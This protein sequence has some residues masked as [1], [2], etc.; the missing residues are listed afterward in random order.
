M[1]VGEGPG[2]REDIQGRPFVGRAG[3]LLDEMLAAIGLDRENVYVTNV[4][5]CRPVAFESGRKRD[6]RPT[7]DEIDACHEYLDQEI[8]LINPK[9]IC[10]LG[11]TANSYILKKFGLR[12]GPI[13]KTHGKVYHT[14][15]RQIMTMYHPAA[16]LYT[17]SLKEE[18]GEDFKKLRKLLAQPTLENWRMG[19]LLG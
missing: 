17:A 9:V 4:V 15:A 18:I 12:P 7:P 10:A 13:G 11:E 6:R 19:R 8:S 1:F 5:K 2:E 3:Q 16:A 14:G